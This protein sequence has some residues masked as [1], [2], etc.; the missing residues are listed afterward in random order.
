ML[1]CQTLPDGILEDFPIVKHLGR[2]ILDFCR[3]HGRFFVGKHLG[4][5]MAYGLWD[6]WVKSAKWL[7]NPPGRLEDWRFFWGN[8][9]E[10]QIFHLQIFSSLGGKHWVVGRWKVG[11]NHIERSRWDTVWTIYGKK[12]LWQTVKLETYWKRWKKKKMGN[13]W[14]HGTRL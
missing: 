14:I 10:F 12:D 4:R 8:G 9:W 5:P 1:V 11:K 3:Q 13:A 2:K 6:L 7:W